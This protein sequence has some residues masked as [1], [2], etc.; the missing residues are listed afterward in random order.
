MITRGHV[1]YTLE[2]CR[3][4]SY[5]DFVKGIREGVSI[6]RLC[7]FGI[8]KLRAYLSLQ[9]G[10]PVLDYFRRIEKKWERITHLPR[11]RKLDVYSMLHSAHGFENELAETFFFV[12]PRAEESFYD[13]LPGHREVVS[14]LNAYPTSDQLQE[15]ML[16]CSYDDTTTVDDADGV[17]T[18]MCDDG[19][20]C[21]PYD[22]RQGRS[23]LQMSRAKFHP[24]SRI[25]SASEKFFD[26]CYSIKSKLSSLTLGGVLSHIDNIMP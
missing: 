16:V 14:L 15:H 7:F 12:F 6:N 13:Q 21:V 22:R 23:I 5:S 18:I 2:F 11:E 9:S 24:D 20:L 3:G 4:Q 8:E 25:V 10:V 26:C 17:V 19:Q 1:R